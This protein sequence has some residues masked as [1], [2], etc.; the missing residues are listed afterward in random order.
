MLKYQSNE[1]ELKAKLVN[2]D[3][4]EAYLSNEFDSLYPL[5]KFIE[6]NYIGNFQELLAQQPQQ[7][8]LP[9][10]EWKNVSVGTLLS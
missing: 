1:Y 8:C 6:Q 5:V 2:R 10:S 3:K 4:K 9:S 7:A